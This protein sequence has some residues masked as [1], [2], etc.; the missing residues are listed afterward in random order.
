MQCPCYLSSPPK[1]PIFFQD[2]DH[3]SALFA[4]L[5]AQS[6]FWHIMH[7]L[8]RKQANDKTQLSGSFPWGMQNC[9]QMTRLNSLHPSLGAC[10]TANKWQD[11]TL[12][13]LPLG[14]AKLQTKAKK[15]QKKNIKNNPMSEALWPSR[16][17]WFS[18]FFWGGVL[19]TFDLLYL[20]LALSQI[21]QNRSA[22]LPVCV[23]IAVEGDNMRLADAM[24]ATEHLLLREL[25]THV[26]K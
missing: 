13:I 14:H 5:F 8:T 6:L 1:T 7:W 4:L 24:S 20:L 26:H 21:L 19:L 12:C 16:S 23:L 15:K 2:R 22:S 25:P 10:K 3:Q 17:S 11:S 9:K 18:C